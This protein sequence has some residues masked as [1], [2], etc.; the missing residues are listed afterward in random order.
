V[1][2]GIFRCPSCQSESPLLLDA[3]QLTCARCRITFS[4]CVCPG[5]AAPQ[6]LQKNEE[7]PCRRCTKALREG[8]STRNV[9]ARQLVGNDDAILPGKIANSETRASI[10]KVSNA[11]DGLYVVDGT[12]WAPTIGEFVSLL[13]LDAGIAFTQTRFSLLSSGRSSPLVPFSMLSTIDVQGYTK[14]KG[15]GFIG[16]GFGAKGALEGMAIST[17]LNALTTKSSNWVIITII[18]DGGSTVLRLDDA[19]Q[20]DIRQRLRTARDQIVASATPTRALP[21]SDSTDL[22]SRLERLATLRTGG[23]LTDDEFQSAKAAL[24]AEALDRPGH[25]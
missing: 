6:I 16:G 20:R 8:K 3:M 23:L 21:A 14:T 19:T 2:D 17:V 25:P 22:V 11:I 5:C 7:K 4:F 15:G 9:T 24:L 1:G 13:T 12:G 18:G 10:E